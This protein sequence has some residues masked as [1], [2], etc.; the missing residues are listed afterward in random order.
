VEKYPTASGNVLRPLDMNVLPCMPSRL[1]DEQGNA[2]A[3][4][5][6]H[7]QRTPAG[8]I[9]TASPCRTQPTSRGRSHDTRKDKA[10]AQSTSIPDMSPVTLR[11]PRTFT[12]LATLSSGP[13]GGHCG[14]R[15]HASLFVT[16]IPGTSAPP[17]GIDSSHQGNS[18]NIISLCTAAIIFH[19]LPLL[20]VRVITTAYMEISGTS[21]SVSTV[22]FVLV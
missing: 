19:V 21:N 6:V 20:Y 8:T 10:P 15:A 14:S 17:T 13:S 4:V 12:P 3:D 9:P 2:A 16:H 7:F 18:M 22:Y 5:I 1:V 11:D